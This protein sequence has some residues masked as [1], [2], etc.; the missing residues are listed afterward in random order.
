M[1]YKN[2]MVIMLALLIVSCGNTK[3]QESEITE[4]MEIQSPDTTKVTVNDTTKFKFDFA[5]ANIPSPATSI[6]ELEGLGVSYDNSMLN[7]TGN[8]VKYADEYKKA[9]NLGVYNID[10][11]YAM[12]NDKGQDVLQYMKGVMML[13]DELGLK[14]AVGGM[15][16]SRAE[17]NLTRKD[18]LFKILDEIFSKSDSY[19]RTNDRLYTAALIFSGS[20]LESLYLNCRISEKATDAKSVEKARRVLWE[21]RFHLGNLTKVLQD[22]KSKKEDEELLGHLNRILDKLM[23]IKNPADLDDEKFKAIAGDIFALRGKVTG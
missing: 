4:G 13:A 2:A 3:E 1:L 15:V 6:Q 11:A 10:M 17:T 5:M 23:A 21:Q 19:L 7:P 12:M 8:V 16:G 22:Y 9:M 18:S 14:N 20:W